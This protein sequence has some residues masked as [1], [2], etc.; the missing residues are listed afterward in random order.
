LTEEQELQAHLLRKKEI[1]DQA[2]AEE[3]TSREEHAALTAEL[4]RRTAEQI[5][6]IDDAKQAALMTN[7]ASVFGSLATIAQAGGKKLAG[8]AKAF[9]IAEALINTYT[10][11]TAALKLPFPMNIAAFAAV[12]ARGLAAVASIA[13]VNTNGAANAQRGGAI[14]RPTAPAPT[15]QAAAPQ[16]LQVRLSGIGPSDFISGRQLGGLL[17]RLNKEAGDRG[18]RLMVPA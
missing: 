4:E 13:S 1:L 8:I 10:G 12:M 2:L 9:G 6:A 7:A 18:F 5:Q 17:D 15:E 16:P 11:A 14:G 3:M